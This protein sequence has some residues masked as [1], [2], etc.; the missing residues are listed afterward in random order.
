VPNPATAR[1]EAV[2]I[3]TGNGAGRGIFGAAPGLAVAT[4]TGGPGAETAPVWRGGCAGSGPALCR[5][6]C[7]DATFLKRERRRS[8]AVRLSA[9]HR[10]GIGSAT[11]TGAVLVRNGSDLVRSRG[12]RH[13]RGDSGGAGSVTAPAGALSGDSDGS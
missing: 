3:P 9:E 8:G 1:R 6:W 11:A 2:A 5:H 4:N 10:I 12:R 13:R 7:G